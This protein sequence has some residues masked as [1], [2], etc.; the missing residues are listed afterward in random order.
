MIEV[1]FDFKERL[2]EAE[3]NKAIAKNLARAKL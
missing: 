3:L 2:H 1:D